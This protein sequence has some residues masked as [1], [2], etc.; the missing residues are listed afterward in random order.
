LAMEVL[1]SSPQSGVSLL[2]FHLMLM[3]YLA[4]AQPTSNSDEENKQTPAAVETDLF[5]PVLI[6]FAKTTL[7]GPVLDFTVVR[8]RAVLPTLF[9]PV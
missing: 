5:V 1:G 2:E 4:W 7:A 8:L 9:F 3:V 6:K